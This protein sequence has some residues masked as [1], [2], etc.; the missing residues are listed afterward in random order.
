[1]NGGSAG[2]LG[3]DPKASTPETAVEDVLQSSSL[4][5]E[6]KPTPPAKP[7]LPATPSSEAAE[8]E[9]EPPLTYLPLEPDEIPT[10]SAPK[11]SA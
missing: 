10:G 2:F 6:P 1:M 4:T 11:G 3:A 9:E 5:A 7:D 8:P